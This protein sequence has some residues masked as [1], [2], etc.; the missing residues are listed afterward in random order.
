[1]ERLTEQQ[2]WIGIG[3][4]QTGSRQVDV[5]RNLNVSQSVVSRLWNRYQNFRTVADLPRTGRPRV[6]TRRQDQLLVTQA[7]RTRTLNATQLQQHLQQ[8]T[9]IRVSTQTVRNRLHQVQ[10]A[11]RR[12]FVA[13]PMSPQHRRARM[14]WCQRH[15]RWTNQQWASVM[16]SDESRFVLDFHDRRIRVW[17]RR[18]ERYQPP[19]TVAHNRYGGGSVMVWAGICMND[20]TDLHICQVNITGLYYRDNIIEPIV[21]PFAQRHGPDFIF[22][23][24]NARP[25]RAR[26]VQDHLQMQHIR[27]LPW[28]PMSPDLSPI[29][30]LWDLLNRRVQQRPAAPQ[31][32][33][34]LAQALQQEWQRIPQDNIRRLICSMKRRCNACLAANGGPTRF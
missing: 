21:V 11:S 26:V 1:M 27:T 13:L 23:D 22:Q 3:M 17:R 2:R 5:A 6:T 30:H 20:R 29:E 12:P 24:D 9:G 33:Q 19:A 10:L 7:L 32:L 14:D 4:L 18:G 8:T 31:T 25:H 34:Q 28:P 16:F 15:H